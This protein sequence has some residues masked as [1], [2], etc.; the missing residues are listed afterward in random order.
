MKNNELPEQTKRNE[1][2]ERILNQKVTMNTNIMDFL[3]I[4]GWK[5]SDWRSPI[6][7]EASPIL[8][9]EIRNYMESKRNILTRSSKIKSARFTGSI[10]NTGT[11]TIRTIGDLKQK[12]ES[13]GIRIPGMGY[14]NLAYFNK[15]LME[16]GLKQIRIGGKS[17]YANTLK[18]YGLQKIKE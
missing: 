13:E 6:Y 10:L 8:K 14:A 1:S 17:S 2:L 3:L 7:K 4:T 5:Y 9:K 11:K 12:I 16:Y 15:K 18:K